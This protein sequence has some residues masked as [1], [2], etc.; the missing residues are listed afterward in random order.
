M[1]VEAFEKANDHI[2]FTGENGKKLKMSECIDDMK[3][4]TRLT[5]FVYHQILLS[6]DPALDEAKAIL[7]KIEKRQLYKCV[8]QTQ[9]S[10]HVSLP[11]NKILETQKEIVESM[12]EA[13]L[14]RPQLNAEDIIVHLVN[15]DYGMKEKNPVNHVRFYLKS[16]PTKAIKIRKDQVSH[17]LPESFSE[18]NIRVY[19]KKVDKDSIDTATKCFNRWC[20]QKDYMAPKENWTFDI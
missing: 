8:G 20:A 15:L 9:P 2:F 5:D 7:H 17:M 12:S 11:S 6:E 4:Y 18:Q 16:N 13:E 10:K 1:I 14:G 3:A 19:V